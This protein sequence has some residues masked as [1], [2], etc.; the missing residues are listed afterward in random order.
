MHLYSSINYSLIKRRVNS[1]AS[2]NITDY[3]LF[4]P[5]NYRHKRLLYKTLSNAG[6]VKG[7]K[8]LV[9]SKGKRTSKH[10]IP[11]PHYSFRSTQLTFM[12]GIIFIPFL[13]KALTLIFTSSGSA[14]YLPSTP[15]HKLFLL[16]SFKKMLHLFSPT[17]KQYTRLYPLFKLQQT[18]K[19]VRQLPKN[20]PISLLE[21]FPNEGVKYIRSPGSVGKILKMDTRTQVSIVRL[22]SKVHKTVSIY[23]LASLGNVYFTE[24]KKLSNTKSGYYRNY[25]L[26]SKVRGVAKNPVD[27]PH[28]GRTKSIKLP[29]T[30][31]GKVAKLKN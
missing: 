31:W 13:N 26:K 21:Q 5:L 14:L 3:K 8:R 15:E 17:Y 27:H 18:F 2:R 24:N 28:G 30:P 23:S 9:F 11:R 16:T 10:L 20:K 25:G 19:V 7:S 1:N 6:R 29:R 22:P 12:A 4:L